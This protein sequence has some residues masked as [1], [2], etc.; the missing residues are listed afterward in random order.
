[1]SNEGFIDDSKNLIVIGEKFIK[2]FYMSE[3]EIGIYLLNEVFFDLDKE[4]L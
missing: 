4:K 3:E 2:K 1:M